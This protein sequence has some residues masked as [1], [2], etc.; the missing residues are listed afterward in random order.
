MMF[1]LYKSVNENTFRKRVQVNQ[2]YWVP[3]GEGG[4]VIKVEDSI[5]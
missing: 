1:N 4:G 2:N 5:S 3:E